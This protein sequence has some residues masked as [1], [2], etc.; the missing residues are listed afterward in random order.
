MLSRFRT[1]VPVVACTPNMQTFYQLSL[2]WGINPLLIEAKQ[3]VEE[4]FREA[5]DTCI[6]QEY[7]K[8]GDLLV[9]TA[10]IPVAV[11]GNTNML[12]EQIVGDALFQANKI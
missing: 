5:I 6:E 11:P 7:C 3:N 4:L 1:D 8:R 2:A 12:K 9:L 10:G